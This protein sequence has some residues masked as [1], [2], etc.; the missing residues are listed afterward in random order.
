MLPRS[1]GFPW[2]ACGKA[3]TPAVNSCVLDILHSYT[4]PEKNQLHGAKGSLWLT[5]LELHV[6]LTPELCA[7]SSTEHGGG[8]LGLANLSHLTVAKKQGESRR[9]QR[10]RISCRGIS[11]LTEHWALS[12]KGLPPPK[13]MKL[14]TEPSTQA[15]H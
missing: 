15:C 12:A 2:E 13:T 1:V 9:G 10:S 8:S 5:L 14:R 11:P 3:L 7:S 6:C 4:T